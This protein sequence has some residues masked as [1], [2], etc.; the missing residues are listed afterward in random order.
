MILLEEALLLL[1]G[2]EGR[3]LRVIFKGSGIR[4]LSAKCSL[5]AV[6]EAGASFVLR[7]DVG[8][9]VDLTGCFIEYGEPP[10]G[11]ENGGTEAAL[12]FGRP[13]DFTLTVMLF[14]DGI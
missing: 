13:G 12:V 2:W 11:E 5:Y 14:S 9:E 7:E 8:F 10:R 6:A 1:K 4:H 3:P